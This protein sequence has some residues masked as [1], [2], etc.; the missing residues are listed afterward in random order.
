M[1]NF[2]IWTE[3]MSSLQFLSQRVSFP[4]VEA[5]GPSTEQLVKLFEAAGRAPDHM[6]LK[7]W[8]FMVIQGEAR[9]EFGKLMVRAKEATAEIDE[10]KRA[11]LYNNAFRAPT[12]IIAITVFKPHEKVPEVEQVLSTGAAVQNMLLA[13]EMM[14]LGGMWRTG[15]MMF[16]P[17]MREGLGVADNETI[18]GAV[19][20]GTPVGKRKSI[21]ALDLD[22]FVSYWRG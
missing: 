16:E 6:Q 18:A 8:R 21:K 9:A 14:G 11:R 1:A 7:P 5:P 2:S 20:L 15:N 12:I 3:P 4:K 19:Y 17:T 13:A 22:K 10:T